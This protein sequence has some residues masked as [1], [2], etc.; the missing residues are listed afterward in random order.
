MIAALWPSSRSPESIH[1]LA[2]GLLA[3]AII[4]VAAMLAVRP[5]AYEFIP[6]RPL[7]VEILEAAPSSDA[8]TVITGESGFP[9]SREQ[10]APEVIRKENSNHSREAWSTAP[11][12]GVN[13]DLAPDRYYTS[14]E[15]DIRAEPMN[16]V[17]L[18]FPRL[19]YQNRTKGLVLLRILINERGAIDDLAVVE[20]HPKGIFEEAALSATRT[21]KF[22]PAIRNGRIVKSQKTIEVAFDPYES[23]HIP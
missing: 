19:A 4:H 12:I 7:Q 10:P 9:A 23:I 22:S 1:R 14:R 21:V 17:Q 3:S 16:D 13:V 15:V 11:T 20:S 2:L 18:V 5:A 8:T 6:V